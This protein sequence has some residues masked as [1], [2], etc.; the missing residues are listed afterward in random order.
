MIDVLDTLRASLAPHYDVEREIGA[1]G[2]ARVFLAV[3]QHPHRRVAIKVLDPEVS[4]RLLRERFIREVDLSSNLSHPHIVPIFSAGEVAGLFYYV[5]PDVE[6]ESLRHRLLADRHL[7]L[8]AALHIARDVADALAFAHGQGIIHRDI[9][10]ENILLSGEHAIVA[11]FGIARAI[12][13]AGSLTLTQAGQPIGSPGYMSPEQAMA[14]G[15]LDA[16]TDL[17]SLGCVLFEM[18]AGESPAASMTERR[19]HNWPVLEAS[20]A[21]KRADARVARAVKHAISRALA[22]LPDDRFPTVTEFA[23]ALGGFPHRTSV[24]TRGVFAS[25]RG[26]RVAVALGVV[27]AMVGVGAAVRL[28]R[29]SGWHL[30]DRRVVVAVIENH[31]GDPSLDNL[32]HMAADWVTQGLA[33][34]GLVEVVP[35][36]SVMSS[37][38]VSGEHGPGHLDAAG[39]KRLA[40]ETGAGT[41]VSGAYYRQADSIRFQIQISAAKDGTVLRAL[42]PVAG[43]IAQPLAAVEAVRQRVMAALA[44]L[45]DA[46]LSQWATTASQPPNFQAYQEFIAGLDRFAQFDMRGAISHFERGPAQDTTFRLPLIFAANA[47]MNLGEF[48]AADSIGHSLERY[49]ARLA[50]LDRAYLAWGL[51]ACP[52]DGAEALRAARAMT[53]LAPGSEALYLV[54]EDAMALNRPREAVDA[55][56]GLAPDRGFTRGWWVYWSDLTSAW[57]LVG[58]HRRELQAALEGLGRVPD[59]PQILATQVRALAALGRVEEMRRGVAASMNL[60]PMEGWAAADVLL[61]AAVELRAHGHAA[62]ADTMLAQARDWLAARPPAEAASEAHQVRVALVAYTAGPL[63][64]AERGFE[65]PAARGGPGR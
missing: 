32:G 13:A 25:R 46:R 24:P 56:M 5:M 31:T 60:P 1:G 48:A 65:S 20:A 55:L 9:K 27:L 15:D 40:R 8:E 52:G 39:V 16:R 45:F 44:T 35:S 57:H 12:S 34:T 18:L 49:A 58:D 63:G 19:V 17:Y 43:P 28:L 59:N 38:L 11:D 61:L 42:D 51:A 3:E 2:M 23:T 50:P 26:R 29:S 7:P 22:P 41:V 62:A 6:G 33:Q 54:A 10:P 64:G 36:V 47:H 21:M 30:N 53:H 14:L 37:S 4:T